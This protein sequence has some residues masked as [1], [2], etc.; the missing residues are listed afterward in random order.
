MKTTVQNQTPRVRHDC[1]SAINTVALVAAVVLAMPTTGVSATNITGHVTLAADADWRG[2]GPV[3][4]ADGA[5]LNLNGH[6]LKIDE[7]AQT[8]EPGEDVTSSSGAVTSSTLLAGNPQIL[9]DNDIRYDFNNHRICVQSF[10]FWVTYDF[11]EG[12]GKCLRAY[13]IYFS[14]SSGDLGRAPKDWTF[15]GSDDNENWTTLDTRTGEIGWR[16]P[17]ARTYSFNN[18]TSYRYYR[19]KVTAVG[20]ATGNTME[21]YQLEYF[22]SPAQY[23]APVDLT[24]PDPS[25]VSS[26]ALFGSS[27]ATNLFDNNKTYDTSHRL[28]AN[29]FPCDIVY[30]FGEGGETALN[31]YKIYYNSG[32]GKVRF[33]INW[34]FEASNDNTIWTALDIREGETNWARGVGREF[35]FANGTPWRYYRLRVRKA[36][37]DFLE[38]Y[39]LEYF[40]RPSIL[41]G[42]D[43]T[44][45]GGDVS[46]S[47][48]SLTGGS[49]GA[50]F[51]NVF[52]RTDSHRLI[53]AKSQLPF[54][55]VYDFGQDA[56]ATV[57]SYKIYYQAG[58]GTRSPQVWTFEGSND[59]SAWTTLDSREDLAGWTNP[60]SRTFS[61]ANANAYRYYKLQFKKPE[62]GANDYVELYQLEF[63][64][65]NGELHV[66]VPSGT[67]QTNSCI[68]MDGGLRFVKD[69]AGSFTAAFSNQT[70][71]SGTIVSN[72][73]L[74]AGLA[75]DA[76]PLGKPHSQDEGN[77]TV[78][79][80]AGGVFDV[81]GLGG[82]WNYPVVLDGG[83]L[84]CAMPATDAPEDT[85]RNI[86]LSSDSRLEVEGNFVMG[87]GTGTDGCLDMGGHVLTASVSSNGLW[88]LNLPSVTAGTIAFDLKKADAQ[89]EKKVMAWETR[90]ADV[91][92]T[93][94]AAGYYDMAVRP[95]GVYV[96]AKATV[97]SF[98]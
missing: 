61:F 37:S 42:N 75:G 80:F 89:G 10:P 63:F 19:F 44:G 81:N 73:T 95:D 28:I 46:K 91:Q 68:A 83:T 33:P 90:P 82:W 60:S 55:V 92:F 8:L 32:A 18:A 24:V 66:D 39:Q 51:D 67:A 78:S 87:D 85:F 27:S 58:S 38:L 11:G 40:F 26:S 62:S 76:A 30:D 98:R 5:T 48:T 1:N 14:T 23:C 17:D 59:N 35:W 50:L 79:V 71:R 84:R 65:E 77:S 16:W 6:T 20:N 54:N 69:G 97:L 36:D 43:L 21:M 2:L 53:V 7:I 47:S 12:N 13:K 15:Q 25:R 34:Q 31:G 74:V 94:A 64:G 96:P 56:N 57:N 93:K 45:P 3:A 22:T 41:S 70:Y 49:V 88:T 9:F 72:G 4:L 86:A 29:T 52:G